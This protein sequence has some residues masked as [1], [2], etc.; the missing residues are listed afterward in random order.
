MNE[1]TQIIMFIGITALIIAGGIIAFTNLKTVDFLDMI[2]NNKTI[3]QNHDN[4][5]ANMNWETG[6]I[7]YNLNKKII[8]ENEYNIFFKKGVD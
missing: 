6:Q 7:E 5:K 8:T 1:N 2:T 3:D 4:L